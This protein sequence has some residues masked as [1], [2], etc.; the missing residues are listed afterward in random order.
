MRA[1]FLSTV[2]SVFPYCVRSLSSLE[3]SP[4][5]YAP[6]LGSVIPGAHLFV[7]SCRGGLVFV[8][9]FDGIL[10][11]QTPGGGESMHIV[12]TKTH[13]KFMK[14]DPI[15]VKTKLKRI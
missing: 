4:K 2:P 5:R 8:K 3:I 6:K 7:K 14:V 12:D 15:L 9:S 10:F 1:S 11:L 13:V